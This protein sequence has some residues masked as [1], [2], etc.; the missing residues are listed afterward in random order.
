MRPTSLNLPP[1]S[2]RS[3]QVPAEATAAAFRCQ[4]DDEGQRNTGE[5]PVWARRGTP[6]I[7]KGVRAL[8]INTS[9]DDELLQLGFNA[10]FTVAEI[11][12]AF[13]AR[14]RDARARWLR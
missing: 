4:F 3:A 7:A 9:I 8:G 5:P 10:V 1:K 11:A 13:A 14:P 6:N 12:L 2:H